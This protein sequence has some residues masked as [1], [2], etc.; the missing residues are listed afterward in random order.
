MISLQ[1]YLWALEDA[2]KENLFAIGVYILFLHIGLV[3]HE[4]GHAIVGALLGVRSTG[5]RFGAKPLFTVVVLGYSVTLG[6][7]PTSGHTTFEDEKNFPDTWQVLA[8]FLAGPLSV[9]F[10]GPVFF[11]LFQHS[12]PYAAAIFGAFFSFHGLYD[13]RASCPDGVAIRR[14]WKV[15]RSESPRQI[16]QLQ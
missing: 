14:L 2:A 15:L 13:L 10:A 8:T 6:W 11:L 1:F 16:G 7:L 9:V 5:I 4:A 12:H 3:I